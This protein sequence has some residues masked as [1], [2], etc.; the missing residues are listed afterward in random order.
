MI[1]PIID[2]FYSYNPSHSRSSQFA[3]TKGQTVTGADKKVL[4]QSS[5]REPSGAATP[6]SGHGPGQG[7]VA[8][9]KLESLHT[10]LGRA[11]LGDP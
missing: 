8:R 4:S 11:R 2:E 1:H 3:R 7:N 10:A 5:T 9:E 6:I